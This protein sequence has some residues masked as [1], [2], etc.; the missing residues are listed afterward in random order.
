MIGSIVSISLGAALGALLR[1]TLALKFNPMFPA[2]P[3]GTLAA[4]LAGG[5]LVGVAIAFFATSPQLPP[6]IR[7]FVITGFLGGLTTFST[8][9]AE[10]VTQLQNGETASALAIA[11]AHMLG[12]FAATALGIATVSLLRQPGA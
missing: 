12:S 4:N 1:W 5:Y 3:L 8:F 11:F 2:L 6:H 9:S 7:L 10:V